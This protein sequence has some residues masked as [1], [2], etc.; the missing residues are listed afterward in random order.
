[1]AGGTRTGFAPRN[2]RLDTRRT[3]ACGRQS[4][5][6]GDE[7]YRPRAHQPGWPSFARVAG[8]RQPAQDFDLPQAARRNLHAQRPGRAQ[9]GIP[10][11]AAPAPGQMGEHRAARHQHRRTA[12]VYHRRRTGQRP[13]APQ[14][15]NRTRILGARCRRSERRNLAGIAAGRGAGGRHGAFR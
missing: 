7:N 12:A 15:G 5:G 2:R 4:C 3:F 10:A 13:D 8:K 6:I 9:I 11:F 1:M 14:R